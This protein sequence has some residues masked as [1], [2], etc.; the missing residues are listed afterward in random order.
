MAHSSNQN[1]FTCHTLLPDCAELGWNSTFFF[2]FILWQ[3]VV[4]VGVLE[5]I[6][7]WVFGVMGLSCMCLGS[8]VQG[9]LF[10]LGGLCSSYKRRNN[11]G[12]EN[13]ECARFWLIHTHKCLLHAATSIKYVMIVLA[14]DVDDRKT[15]PKAQRKIDDRT[16]MLG[17]CLRQK[18]L[19]EW[20]TESG[21][22]L[23][24]H[25]GVNYLTYNNEVIIIIHG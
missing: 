21:K 2:N 5:L 16:R 1:I 14:D 23:L 12:T 9:I 11:H 4:V 10:F 6:L 3:N 24:G 7:G 20:L 13:G 25:A 17:E 15:S 22:P 8:A 19:L 18:N